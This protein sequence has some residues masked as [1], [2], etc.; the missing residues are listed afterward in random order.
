VTEVRCADSQTPEPGREAAFP[1]A[2]GRWEWR[3]L[4]GLLL[5]LLGLHVGHSLRRG[6]GMAGLDAVH[7]YA[8]VRSPVFDGDFD[9][10]NE[11]GELPKG[12]REPVI[13]PATGRAANKYPTGWALV[14]MGPYAIMHAIWSLL[15]WAC[16]SNRVLTGYELPYQLAATCSQ[17]VAGWAGAVLSYRLARTW[18][19]PRASAGALAVMLLG[20][21]LLYYIVVAPDLSHAAGFFCVS[22]LIYLCFLL[23]LRPEPRRYHWALLGLV[24]ALMVLVRYSNVLFA[25]VLVFPA[26]AHLRRGRR[27]AGKLLV[28]CLIAAAAATPLV[29]YQMFIWRQVYGGWLVFSYGQEGLAWNCP[30]LASYLFSPRKGVFFWSPVLL[31]AALGVGWA[32]LRRPRNLP[33]LGV[34]AMALAAVLLAILNASWW[35][36]SFG[37]SFGN[38]GYVE[39]S[40]VL[41]LGLAVLLDPA[42]PALRRAVLG[43]ACL[44]LAWTGLLLALH[45]TDCLAPNGPAD[46]DQLRK[47]L[48][49]FFS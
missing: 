44:C 35:G 32:L 38:R 11:I 13:V 45:A 46:L 47:A 33:A 7:Y 17:V 19:C 48:V 18:F 29:L 39:A 40:T 37:D 22:A 9:F 14:A 23:A 26:V 41:M 4:L 21:P 43:I 16:G 10:R 24:G 15:L 34:G 27:S 3:T 8:Q 30:K 12:P 5:V 1:A 36:W 2:L 31:P 49:T 6:Y 42:R 25:V 28:G 20:S